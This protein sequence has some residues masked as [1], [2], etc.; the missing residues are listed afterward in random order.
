[1]ARF[2]LAGPVVVRLAPF[3]PTANST[4]LT[5]MLVRRVNDWQQAY[6]VAGRWLAVE[7]EMTFM[8]TN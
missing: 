4:K 6:E 8:K 7:N 3:A 5:R 1:M 2:G